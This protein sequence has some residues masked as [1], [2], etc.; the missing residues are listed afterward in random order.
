[1]EKFCVFHEVSC[2]KIMNN[3]YVIYY[4]WCSEIYLQQ[5]RSVCKFN[6]L[7]Q[8]TPQF[9]HEKLLVISTWRKCII[10]PESFQGNIN[11]WLQFSDHKKFRRANSPIRGRSQTTFTRFGFF[12]PPTPLRLHFLRYKSLQKAGP[13]PAG[14]LG[15]L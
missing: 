14:G 12:Y 13:S 9:L 15:G 2:L 10:L 1:M 6:F 4:Y 3:L 11:Y 8:P 5:R 7:F